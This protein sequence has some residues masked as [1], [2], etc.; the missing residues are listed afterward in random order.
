[1]QKTIPTLLTHTKLTG[2]DPLSD[3]FVKELKKYYGATISEVVTQAGLFDLWKSFMGSHPD[4]GRE[5][6]YGIL[7]RAFPGYADA[8]MATLDKLDEY[9]RWLEHNKALLARMSAT[10]RLEAL[11]K[12]RME[13]FG[14]D[15]R[16]IWTGE[17]LAT[18]SRRAKV[19]DTLAYLNQTEDMTMDDKIE[20]YQGS[21]REA[22]ENTPEKFILDQG[23]LLAK[24]FFSIDSVQNEL[25]QMTPLERQQELNRIRRKMGF[26][27]QQVERMEKRDADN[28]L[29]WEAG[30][31]YMKDREEIVRQFEGPQQEEKLR[32]LR[33]QYFD[34]EAKTIELEEKGDFFRFKRQ[35]IYGRN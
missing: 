7:K 1:V 14:D 34:D 25:K 22:Y 6:F 3:Q 21:L 27:E 8:I 12:K 17:E 24:V 31:N 4:R 15:A 19:Q 29:R 23:P 5:L 30:L 11:Q 18:E 2:Q 10:E 33:E 35:H 9:N 32:E 20:V 13:L 28:E 16:K 26:T